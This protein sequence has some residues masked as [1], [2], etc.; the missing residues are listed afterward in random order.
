M[1]VVTASPYRTI[2][3]SIYIASYTGHSQSFKLDFLRATLKNWDWPGYEASIYSKTHHKSIL[4]A[5]PFLQKRERIR[6][7]PVDSHKRTSH[8]YLLRDTHIAQGGVPIPVCAYTY[9]TGR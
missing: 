9:L 5:Y 3:L 2:I 4:V 8:Q 6:Y 7:E 1:Y